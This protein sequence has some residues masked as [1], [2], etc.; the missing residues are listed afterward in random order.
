MFQ[1]ELRISPKFLLLGYEKEHFKE[2]LSAVMYKN[3]LI[4]TQ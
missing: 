1:G 3:I 4:N 2:N